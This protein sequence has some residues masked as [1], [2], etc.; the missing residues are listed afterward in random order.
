MNTAVGV[1]RMLN[2]QGQQVQVGLKTDAESVA[3]A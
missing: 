3:T 2:A 1:V